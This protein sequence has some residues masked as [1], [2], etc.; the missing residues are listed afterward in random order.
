MATRKKVE[1]PPIPDKTSIRARP[2][3]ED[4]K[5]TAGGAGDP[6]AAQIKA[7][8]EGIRLF[9][10]HRFSEAKPHFE[11]AAAGPERPV[12]LTARTHIAVCERRTHKPTL[13]LESA[14][15]H[16]NYGIER[17]N[18]RDLEAARKHLGVSLV[19][20][21]DT[22]H[23]HYALGAAYSLSGDYSGAYEN[24]KR[25]I[26]IEPRNRFTARQDPDYAG[27]VHNPLFTPL[28]FPEKN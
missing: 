22:E 16:Y 1:I 2:G 28:L 11:R 21:P 14:D 6:G 12:A 18:A 8:E 7:L 19:L 9:R 10:S 24:L 5:V 13:E 27:V 4:S 25:A 23:A 26:E 3:A 17:L 15:D 20:R